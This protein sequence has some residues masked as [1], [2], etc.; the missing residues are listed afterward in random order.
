[1]KKENL[2]TI[3]LAQKFRLDNGL[4][5]HEAINIKSLLRKL[6]ILTVFLPLMEGLVLLV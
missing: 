4:S 5:L 1:M 3:R 2:N 6:N